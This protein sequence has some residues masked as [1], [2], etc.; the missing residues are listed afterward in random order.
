M[1]KAKGTI[2]GIPAIKNRLNKIGR[3]LS[4]EEADTVGREAVAK[5][6]ELI[7]RGISPVRGNGLSARFPAYIKPLRY[8]G[9]RKPRSPVNLFLTGNF[10]ADLQYR[11]VKRKNG[12]GA[13]IGYR[14]EKQRLKEKGHRER[15]HGQP[16]RPTIPKA[17]LGERF[18]RTIEDAY[19]K[20]IFAAYRRR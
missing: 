12:F 15:S 3:G 8:P 18:A 6:K 14:D 9:K 10:L 11:V 17:S 4:R 16:S 19:L 5:M 7:S 20:I 1:S 13:D 2:A